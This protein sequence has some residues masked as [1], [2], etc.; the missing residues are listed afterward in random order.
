MTLQEASNQYQIPFHILK[1]YEDWGLCEA[2]KK[3]VGERQYD[4]DDLERLGL[5]TT[6]Y[7]IVF[8]TEEVEV[9]MRLLEEP[10]S[11]QTRL[12]MLNQRRDAALD[13]LHLRERLLQRLDHLRHEIQNQK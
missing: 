13:E 11:E 1:E 10:K 5:I 12:R 4:Q 7:D 9:Y 3:V 8:S 2:A 6:L